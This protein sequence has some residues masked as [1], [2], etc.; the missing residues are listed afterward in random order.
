MYS[1]S[2]DNKVS[3][4]AHG[5][6]LKLVLPRAWAKDGKQVKVSLGLKD[7]ED[8][9][10]EAE[11]IAQQIERDYAQDRLKPLNEY[12]YDKDKEQKP[13]LSLIPSNDVQLI[14]LWDKY[15]N[16]RAN[17]KQVAET[18]VILNYQRVSGH[19]QKNPYKL[20]SQ[21]HEMF[22]FL[23]ENNS[24]KT[25]K[26]IIT[27]WNAC[28]HWALT[29]KY[30]SK[31]P[32]E[33]LAATIKEPKNKKS[34]E[35]Q[36][37]DTDFIDIDPFT[38][39]EMRKILEAFKNHHKYHHYYSLVKFFFL[40]GC[41]TSEAVGLRWR[42]INNDCSMVTFQE[43]VVCASGKLITKRL[44]NQDFRKFPCNKEL[45]NLLLSIKPNIIGE[46]DRIFKSLT[47]KT[48]RADVFNGFVWRG[49]E[50]KGATYVG[51]VQQLAED[52]AI[53]HYRPQYQTRHTFITLALEKG[54][55]VK[56]IAR[57]VGNS[58]EIIYKHYAGSR[59]ESITVPDLN[60]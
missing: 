12:K 42:H 3:I 1:K 19:I 59:L 44:K 8:G 26:R 39:D 43:A 18:T 60:I 17:N 51:I 25:A 45:Q 7:N 28:C 4:I 33:G 34:I 52:G 37:E 32:F 38:I 58:P 50:N 41:R 57:L 2:K 15:V 24:L 35:E 13:K 30:I 55:E 40:T 48:I 21:S 56:D 6:S 9:W 47:G 10:R 14:E 22:T 49:C 53:D 5:K 36:I 46:D 20:L 23:V 31:N 11:L 27:Q 16:F 29:M 54:M